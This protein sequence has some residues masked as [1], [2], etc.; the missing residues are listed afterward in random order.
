[1]LFSFSFNSLSAQANLFKVVKPP[2]N[3]S[4]DQKE[5]IAKIEKYPNVQNVTYV[6]I[7]DYNTFIE[8]NHV[9]FNIPNSLKTAKAKVRKRERTKD[10]DYKFYGTIE[11]ENQGLLGEIQLIKE[12][13]LVFGTMAF[14]DKTYRIYGIDKNISAVLSFDKSS[15]KGS[16]GHENNSS[17]T[18]TNVP[19]ENTNEPNRINAC[20]EPRIRTLILFSQAADDID[21]NINQTAA[22]CI[23]QYNNILSNSGITVQEARMVLAGTQLL[24]N[25]AENSF[26]INNDVDDL[27]ASG[28]ANNLRNLAN[29]DMVILLTDGNYQLFLP[30][31][32]F[33]VWGA[34]DENAI[35][36][37]DF[38]AYAIVEADAAVTSGNY[39]FA[40]EVAHLLGGRHNNDT[41]GPAYVHAFGFRLF[42]ASF[43]PR[44]NTILHQKQIGALEIPFYANP[45]VSITTPI[46]NANCCNVTRRITEIAPNISQFRGAPNILTTSIIGQNFISNYGTYNYEPDITCGNGPYTTTW[47]VSYNNQSFTQVVANDGQLQLNFY[48]GSS[49][50]NTSS[51]DIRMTVTSNDGQVS[52]SFLTLSINILGNPM[53]TPKG[54]NGGIMN[55]YPNPANSKMGI[56][57]VLESES[58][59]NIILYDN[60]GK[61][62]KIVQQSKESKGYHQIEIDTKELNSGLYICKIETERGSETKKLF[63][64][65]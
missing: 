49:T 30:Q 38:N 3:L 51:I 24:P 63:I 18:K 55:L 6:K 29:A 15:I 31:G 8:D 56:D 13:D 61:P 12:N 60:Q 53:I 28:A 20:Q 59:V 35:P 43:I 7:N 33:T 50:S 1:V 48:P 34:V 11:S 64:N 47:E 32:T 16:C 36:A 57:Y 40:H 14:E 27:L 52:T 23:D 58:D 21:P 17:T 46:G 19:N 44:F 39:T 2:F 45:N 65:H 10:N 4:Q 22:T 37:E 54:N 5:M 41:E 62:I 25:F 26:N 9:S 42:N